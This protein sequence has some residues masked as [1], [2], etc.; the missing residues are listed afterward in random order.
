MFLLVGQ[1][2]G[3]KHRVESDVVDEEEDEDHGEED[4][5]EDNPELLEYGGGHHRPDKVHT[6]NYEKEDIVKN[7]ESIHE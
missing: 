5:K 4:S 7:E 6:K 3:V 1:C 2:D